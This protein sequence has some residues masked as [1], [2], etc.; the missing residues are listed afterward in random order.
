MA[1]LMELLW[2][3]LTNLLMDHYERN[4]IF[5]QTGVTE[6]IVHVIHFVLLKFYIII[7]KI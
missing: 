7:L 3:T 2:F 4:W 5:N 1:K 6:K